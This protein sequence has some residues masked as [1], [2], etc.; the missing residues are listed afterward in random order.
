MVETALKKAYENGQRNALIKLGLSRDPTSYQE[1]EDHT[2][3]N[4]AMGVA[5][6]APFAGMVGEKPLVHAGKGDLVDYETL[7]K[8]VRPGDVLL[9]GDTEFGFTK[10][11]VNAA[12]GTPSGYHVAV[13]S[14]NKDIYEAHP[15][16]GLSLTDF[17]PDKERI[18]V[19]RPKLES[20]ELE[21]F[22]GNLDTAVQGAGDFE[23]SLERQ[24]RKKGYGKIDAADMAE[25]GRGSLYDNPQGIKAGLKELFLP[26]LRQDVG[27]AAEV[28]KAE[29]VKGRQQFSESGY[30]QHAKTVADV[31]DRKMTTGDQRTQ[32][33]DKNF[34]FLP[35][36]LRGRL[37]PALESKHVRPAM[38]DCVGGVCSTL[39]AS[40]MPAGKN[41]IPSKKPSDVLPNDF[42]RSNMFE[43]VARYDPAPY[44]MHDKVLKYGPTLARAGVGLGLAG[45]V[46]GSSKLWDRWKAKKEE[47]VNNP[48]PRY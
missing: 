15:R 35:E 21:Q 27:N 29:Y 30:K 22:I 1:D 37:G 26:K 11:I 41:V 19:L 38:P 36:R 31:I 45:A 5:A 23:S 34:G 18:Q 10:G 4:V 46:Y 2:A 9:T 33:I 32:W 3:R 47:S 24:L 20:H 6:A 42:L 16:Y 14:P 40:A 17:S 39:P 25:I 48:T 8:T 13:V 12:S 7:R 43:P 28:Q 44:Q